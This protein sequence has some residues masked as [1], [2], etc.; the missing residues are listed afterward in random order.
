MTTGF[1]RLAEVLVQRPLVKAL[2][3]ANKKVNSTTPR[4]ESAQESDRLLVAAAILD[5]DRQET[6]PKTRGWDMYQT[7]AY[8]RQRHEQTRRNHRW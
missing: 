4:K 7:E 8:W 5:E 3:K 2:V 6:R 1:D